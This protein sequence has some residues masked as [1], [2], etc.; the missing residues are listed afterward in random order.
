[1]I[2]ID[3]QSA[4]PTDLFFIRLRKLDFTATKVCSYRD[5]VRINGMGGVTVSNRIRTYCWLVFLNLNVMRL[6]GI[7]LSGIGASRRAVVKNRCGLTKVDEVVS[8]ITSND[9]V[10]NGVGNQSELYNSLP[11]YYYVPS[12]GPA[13]FAPHQ[14][15]SLFTTQVGNRK[16]SSLFGRLNR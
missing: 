13:Y 4:G 7:A 3:K 8:L 5:A 9:E 2:V 1:M 11:Y 12:T 16:V 6:Q 14:G 15:S 10:Q